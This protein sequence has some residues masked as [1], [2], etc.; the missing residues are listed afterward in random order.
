MPRKRKNSAI[1]KRLTRANELIA[2][3]DYITRKGLLHDIIKHDRHL[4]F[5]AVYT[6]TDRLISLLKE[7]NKIEKTEK[8]GIY[9]VIKHGT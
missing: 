5:S 3:K 8:P 9:K 1:E 2:N 6:A 7:Q 4:A